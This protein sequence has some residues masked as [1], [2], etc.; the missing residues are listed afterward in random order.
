MLVHTVF[1]WL[2]KD[3]DG[4]QQ[5]EFRIA[6]ETLKGIEAAEAVHIGIPAPTPERPVID[7]SYD[8]CLMLKDMAT[9]DAYQVDPLHTAFIEGNKR[10]GRKSRFTTPTSASGAWGTDQAAIGKHDTSNAAAGLGPLKMQP[11]F[12]SA[13][14]G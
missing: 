8:F 3:L 1:F 4:P 6:L 13:T 7:N 14:V 9:H 11:L 2:N 12:K 5:T 10:S